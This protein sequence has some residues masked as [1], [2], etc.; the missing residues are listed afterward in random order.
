MVVV[1]L[2]VFICCVV[3]AI[4]S[5]GQPSSDIYLFDINSK[6][7]HIVLQRGKNIANHKGYDNQPFFH[8]DKPL[9]YYASADSSGQTDILVYNYSTGETSKV[10]DTPEHEY[11]PTV[12]PD[13]QFI[14]CIIQRLD[15]V[16]DLAK[17]PLNGGTPVVIVNNLT[18]G[19]HAWLNDN[20]VVLFVLGEPMTLRKVSVTTGKDTILAENIGR[21]IHRIPKKSSIS[22]VQK[23]A[24]GN[25]TINMID[26]QAQHI[27]TIA[28]TLPNRED[29]AWT[30]D[31]RILMSDDGKLY[32]FRP[33]DDKEWKEV[34]IQ[35]PVAIKGITR[36]QVNNKG[37]KIAVVIAE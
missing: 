14:S 6:K 37:D 11:S 29:L 30:P 35:S 7:E 1:R 13:K 12:T 3:A 36:I 9:L 32:S 25:W 19:Y 18:V 16:Q 15:G 28:T 20:T 24:P 5:S 22:F 21:S 17:Y 26:E 23:I 33:G 34:E 31:G 10:T 2:F 27:T 8:P 4:T